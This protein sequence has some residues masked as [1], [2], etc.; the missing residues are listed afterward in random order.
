[1]SSTFKKSIKY[2]QELINRLAEKRSTIKNQKV[3]KLN[4]TKKFLEISQNSQKKTCVRVSGTD[5]SL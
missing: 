2:S 3:D 1:M 5:V 4:R